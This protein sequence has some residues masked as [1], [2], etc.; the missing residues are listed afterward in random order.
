[1]NTDNS[2]YDLVL[3]PN[4]EIVALMEIKDY[5][6]AEKRARGKN[7]DPRII[8][9]IMALAGKKDEAFAMFIDY[10]EKAPDNL[11]ED[12][13]LQ[14]VSLV[15]NASSK[16]SG[17]LLDK[18]IKK[19]I[20]QQE[21]ISVKSRHILLSVQEGNL[22]EADKKMNELLDSAMPMN[23]NVKYVAH[24]LIARLNMDSKKENANTIIRKL[25]ERLPQDSD[26]LIQ[27]ISSLVTVDPKKALSELDKIRQNNQELYKKRESFL[28]SLRAESFRNLGEY[29]RAKKIYESL[30]KSKSGFELSAEAF[31]KEYQRREERI[32]T[33]KKRWAEKEKLANSKLENHSNFF[34]RF[35]F[36]FTIN[37][38]LI[39][40]IVYTIFWRKRTQS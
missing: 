6:N 1:L 7:L 14:S 39:T 34:Y 22:L 30:V 40:L 12:L 35:V 33:E 18:L 38:I 16:M 5:A 28:E 9:T 26:V 19:G 29:E 15:D 4:A 11:K 17:D 23:V 25:R 20:L 37:L 13:A 8:A 31:F 21:S 10:L 24:A 2:I 36:V 3:R 27:W 32:N